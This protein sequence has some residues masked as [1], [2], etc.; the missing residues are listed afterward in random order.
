MRP[1]QPDKRRREETALFLR[2]KLTNVSKERTFTPMDQN[3]VRERGLRPTD[4]YIVT[5][6]GKSI[7][8]FPLA[9]DSEWSIVGQEFATLGPGDSEET[10]VAAEPGSAQDVGRRDDLACPAADRRLSDRYVGPCS[11]TR[12]EVRHFRTFGPGDKP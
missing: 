12:D 2:L 7:R 9:I 5:S 3:L 11:F 4:P 8:L 6:E 1:L 10:F